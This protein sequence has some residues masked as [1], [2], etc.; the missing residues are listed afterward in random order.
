MLQLVGIGSSNIHILATRSSG[1]NNK[2]P[3]TVN[4]YKP[5]TIYST[6]IKLL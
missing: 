5:N 1:L 6:T 2:I 4:K 3:C